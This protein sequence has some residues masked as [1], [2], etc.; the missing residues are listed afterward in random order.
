MV[1]PGLIKIFG[2]GLGLEI[3]L[4]LRYAVVNNNFFQITSRIIAHYRQ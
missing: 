1:F 4:I 3:T 2:E